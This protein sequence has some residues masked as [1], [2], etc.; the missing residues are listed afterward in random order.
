M[1]Q[2]RGSFFMTL[3]SK[4][5]IMAILLLAAPISCATKHQTTKASASVRGYSE[6]WLDQRTI[7]IDF[8]GGNEEK[9]DRLKNQAVLRAAELGQA[10]DFERFLILKTTDQIIIDGVLKSG[11]QFLPVEKLKVSV[12]V[13]F[14]DDKDPEYT[15]AFDIDAKTAEIRRGMP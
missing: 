12:T 6:I 14:V 1:L 7:Q 4:S 10:K 8:K 15:Q 5:F 11:D 2:K 9:V 13:R 3:Q